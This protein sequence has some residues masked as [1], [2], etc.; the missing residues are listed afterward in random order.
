MQAKIEPGNINK[1]QISPTIQATKSNFLQK[2]GGRKPYY[3]EYFL[4]APNY[5][6]LVD[7]IQSEQ[8]SRFYKK[9]NR[10]I[11]IYI[12]HD[13]P[14]MPNYRWMTLGQIKQ[15]MKI[16]NIVNMDTRT[17]LSCIPTSLSANVAHEVISYFRDV[18]LYNSIFSREQSDKELVSLFN[19]IN[20]YKMFQE[21]K[22][23]LV[24]LNKLN[25]WRI[26]DDKISC[27]EPYN[28]HV[29]FCDIEVEG[30]EVRNWMQ[31]LFCA[32]GNATFGL[33]TCVMDGKRKFLIH[34]QA[35]YGCFDGIELGP[36]IQRE[37]VNN[38]ER[39]EVEKKFFQQYNSKKGI[40]FD[41][42][43][44]EEGGRFY[45]E[46]N[47]NIILETSYFEPTEGYYWISYYT[48][49]LMNQFNNC[50]NI[51]LRNLL[52]LLEI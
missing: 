33:Y 6:V 28:F 21:T 44:S 38:S 22:C 12:N 1:V 35:E 25:N 4:N 3:L 34:L 32:E 31:P 47:K 13:V 2:H 23:T 15:L 40:L 5:T 48:L 11:I 45:H 30:R 18:T 24:G 52:S 10:N 19:H 26:Q 46:Q 14:E 27:I 42:F 36:T 9:R 16:D 29:I 43:L 17:V 8:S 7:Q 39:D 41:A 20:N 37:Y 50:L 51:Q 49:N